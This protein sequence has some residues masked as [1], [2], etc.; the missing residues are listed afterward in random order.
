[1]SP[2]DNGQ[3]YEALRGISERRRASRFLAGRAYGRPSAG[4]FGQA[5]EVG[6]SR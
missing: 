5:E 3:V 1:M 2:A 4:L 6:H